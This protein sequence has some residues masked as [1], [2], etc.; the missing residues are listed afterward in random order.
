M[1]PSN[2]FNPEL[3]ILARESRGY[4]QLQLADRCSLQQGT[5]SKLESGLLPLSDDLA[6]RLV[7]ALGYP[8]EFYFR[9]D[10]VFG[11]NSSIFFHRK[12]Q[13]LSDRILRRLHAQMNVR[14]IHIRSLLRAAEIDT[15]NRFQKLDLAEYRCR[16][17]IIAQLVRSTWLIPRGPV[18]NV[19]QA[20]EDAGGVVIR[21]DFGTRQIDA[22]SE[23]VN[24]HPPLFAV[25]ANTEITGDRLRRTLAHEI[26]HVVMHTFPAP[27]ME[28]EA[29]RF[30]SEFLMPAREIK[31]CLHNLTIPKLA[32]I[33]AEWGVSMSSV[34]NRAY[35]LKRITAAQRRLLFVKLSSAGYAT[36][37]PIETDILIE[38]PTLV[39]ELVN[40]HTRELGFTQQ[41][42][43][44]LVGLKEREFQDLYT[45]RS[46]RL[47]GS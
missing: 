36:R 6:K 41:D 46:L 8:Y 32:D 10:R 5:I 22:I 38:K 15:K 12:R 14:R 35:E 43:A 28:E 45:G 4:T 17:D 11:F 29:E 16:A 42:V 9:R 33:K 30:A 39:D 21:W 20:I 34:V 2:D 25:N 19:T 13:A 23:W 7:D 1:K 26:G 24:G 3:V 40:T 44:A 31:S 18:Q 37:E 47:V 27:K